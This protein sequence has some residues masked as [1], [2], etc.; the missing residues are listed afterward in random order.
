MSDTNKFDGYFVG[1]VV[2]NDDPEK[3]GRIKVKVKNL[4][5]NVP[6]SDIPWANPNFTYTSDTLGIVFIPKIG[7][8]AVVKFNR[9]SY[10]EMIWVG[11]VYRGKEC[12]TPEEIKDNYPERSIIKTKAAY[13]MFDDTAAEEII[14]VVH[15]SGT[16]FTITPEGNI[17]V[18]C[19]GT[20]NQNIDKDLNV[21]VSGNINYTASGNVKIK[22]ARI[23]LN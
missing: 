19:V 23:D 18:K 4:F 2:A 6:V 14:T 10:Y 15:K 11:S 12:T 17:E 13:I 20:V 3:K 9:S 21:N 7:S 5:G 8:L 16:Q 22:G 1:E